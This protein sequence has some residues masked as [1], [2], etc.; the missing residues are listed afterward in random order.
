MSR[1][2]AVARIMAGLLLTALP[3]RAQVFEGRVLDE[4]DGRP[5]VTALVRLLDDG[6]EPL[7]VAV[8]DTAGRYRIELPGP[9]RYHLAAERI[10]YDPF[11][12]HL[13]EVADA[14]RTYPVDVGLRAV[15]MPIPGFVVTAQRF[16]EVRRGIRQQ[17]G[18]STRALRVQPLMRPEIEDHLARAH[19]VSD[20]VR[21]T[22]LPGI[23][24]EQTTDGPCFQYR[25]SHCV[26]VYLD[27][28]RVRPELV[29]VLPLDMAE[30]IVFVMPKETIAY[31]G[32]AVLLYTAGWI[33]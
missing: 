24:V 19:G 1:G 10:G 33:R 9:G 2:M 22:N 27:G 13:L 20:V 4:G 31:P 16:E 7:A 14:G 12:S 17:I 21:W 25:Q 6:L 23:I 28:M 30:T 26:D 29:D 5:V 8:S 11:T 3:A 32:G 18:T 15:P